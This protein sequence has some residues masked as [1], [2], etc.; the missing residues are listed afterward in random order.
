M[1]EYYNNTTNKDSMFNEM[2]IGD[3]GYNKNIKWVGD[4][5]SVDYIAKSHMKFHK[6]TCR[7]LIAGIHQVAKS[8]TC[9]YTV[10]SKGESSRKFKGSAMLR[11]CLISLQEAVGANPL[12]THLDQIS[13]N[14]YPCV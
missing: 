11:S 3:F 4:P 5:E 12:Y 14:Y 8:L 6:E 1:T 7:Q 13:T 9:N 10:R 2:K